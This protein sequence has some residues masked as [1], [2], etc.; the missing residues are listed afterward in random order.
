MKYA[1]VFDSKTGNTAHI[2]QVIHDT[3]KQ[4]RCVSFGSHLPKESVDVLFLGSWCD[5]GGFSDQMKELIANVHEQKIA[6]FAT[7][8]FGMDSAYFRKIADHMKGQLP[9]DNEVIASFVC[10]G[11]M[12]QAIRTRYESMLDKEET[13]AMALQMIENF[14]QAKTHPDAI[15]EKQAAAFA[16]H[17]MAQCG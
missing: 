8:G 5:K 16:L 14:D 9:S 10:Q 13:H 2:A 17:A 7:C 12:P 1:I 11:K 3:L 6:V 4:D 15:D